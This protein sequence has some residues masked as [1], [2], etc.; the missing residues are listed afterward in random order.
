MTEIP[1]DNMEAIYAYL[2]LE[3]F[4]GKELQQN[5]LVLAEIDA[6]LFNNGYT[7]LF[8]DDSLFSKTA[9]QNLYTSGKRTALGGRFGGRAATYP[10]GYR[11]VRQG[12]SEDNDG[13][14]QPTRN[15]K[16]ADY[17]RKSEQVD[18]N[19]LNLARTGELTSEFQQTLTDGADLS[20]NTGGS[21]T[22]TTTE[23]PEVAE[24]TEDI[25][26]LEMVP[27]EMDVVE[28][29]DSVKIRGPAR[30]A[31]FF[32]LSTNITPPTE[33][34]QIA[35]SL[36]AWKE[37]QNP[38][39]MW[40]YEGYIN[41]TLRPSEFDERMQPT[42]TVVVSETSEQGGAQSVDDF[43]GMD[44][45][46]DD[47]PE[48]VAV[49]NATANQPFF[50]TPEIQF[51]FKMGEAAYFQVVGGAAAETYAGQMFPITLVNTDAPAVV[52]KVEV[53]WNEPSGDFKSTDTISNFKIELTQEGKV[54]EL[55]MNE[56]GYLV[57][58]GSPSG[59]IY[60]Q[61][62]EDGD[63]NT[64]GG[65]MEKVESN[66][67]V[68]YSHGGIGFSGLPNSSEGEPIDTMVWGNL[69]SST[70]GFQGSVK[71]NAATDVPAVIRTQM[72]RFYGNSTVSDPRLN[73]KSWGD[74]PESILTPIMGG[75]N[76][77]FNFD[78]RPQEITA[79]VKTYVEFHPEYLAPKLL[80]LTLLR[81]ANGAVPAETES[82]GVISPEIIYDDDGDIDDAV[83]S[84]VLNFEV[85][86][87]DSSEYFGS[88]QKKTYVLPGDEQHL[89]F[90]DVDGNEV[91][92]GK[93][94]INYITYDKPSSIMVDGTLVA[95]GVRLYCEGDKV[96]DIPTTQDTGDFWLQDPNGKS[97]GGTIKGGELSPPAPEI[98]I[99]NET[100]TE[101][102][103]DRRKARRRE[104]QSERFTNRDETGAVVTRSIAF[105]S[106]PTTKEYFVLAETSEGF[107]IMKIDLDIRRD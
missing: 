86:G 81:D 91:N 56:L 11:L 76:V 75:D 41:F 48:E 98:A 16:L 28:I 23:I 9:L 67:V 61:S 64:Y 3:G 29:D 38:D 19:V 1:R 95:R 34:E 17:N 101:V 89:I 6:L 73:W 70:A 93:G 8:N 96:I 74:D 68:I 35:I 22:T 36:K 100:A 94:Q 99:L 31:N 26:S 72:S 83:W 44:D 7:T 90:K 21:T 66:E 45:F 49:V 77:I 32:D 102:W 27:I 4:K 84:Q 92:V 105:K 71:V 40:P 63:Y 15:L 47:S 10:Y 57:Q 20:M 43:M 13:F 50:L 46:M 82:T 37:N 18:A 85:T 107:K 59:V 25:D 52:T 88:S 97:V 30:G 78:P 58:N 51:G 55:T 12:S 24:I 5:G 39:K 42:N 54:V 103:N 87:G 80:N 79:D 65:M 2:M 69:S 33:D 14:K 106:S 104:K 62:Q 60:N 53:A